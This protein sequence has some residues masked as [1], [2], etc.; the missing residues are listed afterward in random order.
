MVLYPLKAQSVRHILGMFKYFQFCDPARQESAGHLRLLVW[1]ERLLWA[2]SCDLTYNY[3]F[4]SLV[5]ILSGRL[6]VY[7]KLVK[8]ITNLIFKFKLFLHF[9]QQLGKQYKE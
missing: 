1:G 9:D 2:Q 7:L 5:H 6:L 4:L 3:F 8:K